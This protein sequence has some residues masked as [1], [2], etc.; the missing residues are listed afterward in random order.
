MI[1]DG[2]GS[3]DVARRLLWSQLDRPPARPAMWFA[4]VVYRVAVA[5]SVALSVVAGLTSIGAVHAARGARQ[6]ICAAKLE[7][8]EARNP[9]LAKALRT[10]GNACA[11][12]ER[13]VGER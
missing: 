3:A 8:W 7:A 5:V 4:P 13:L 6:E 1:M 12:L 9:S 11:D 2:G 10:H